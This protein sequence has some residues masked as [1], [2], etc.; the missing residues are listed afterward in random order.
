VELKWNRKR[1]SAKDRRSLL[2]AIRKLRVRKAYFVTAN[3]GSFEYQRLDKKKHEKYKLHELEVRLPDSV[4]L[5]QWSGQRE[6]IRR[7]VD[8]PS[9]RP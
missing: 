5:Q 4:N 1:I 7:L 9:N 3:Y 8:F 6:R 2:A